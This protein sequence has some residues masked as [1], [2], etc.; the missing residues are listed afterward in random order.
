MKP[1]LLAATASLIALLPAVATAEDA[2]QPREVVVKGQRAAPNVP[3]TTEGVTAEALGRAVNVVTPEDALRYVPNVLIR[4][5]HFGDTQSPVTTRTSGVGASG[6]S[7][8]Y[9]DGILISSLIGN[10]NTSASPKWGLIAPDAIARVDVMYGPFSAA[11][12]GNSIGSVIAFTTRMPQ[13]FEVS[14]EVQGAVQK[15]QRYGDDDS[16]GTA[17]AATSI[18]NRTGA[19]AWRLNYNHLDTRSQPLS[20]VTAATAPAGTTGAFDDSNRLGQPIKVL[21][22]DGLEHQVQDNLSGRLTWDV[23]PTLTAA[24]TFGV[25]RNDDDATV[26]SYLKDA[27]GAPAYTPAFSSGVYHF[28][29]QQIA[30]GLSLTSHSGGV[31]DYHLS[32][33]N[34][35]YD[36]SR[37]RTPTAPPQVAFTGGAGVLAQ[38]DGT[39]WRTFDA[40]GTW[41][42]AQAH[43]VTFGYHL[44]AFRLDNPRYALADWRTNAP[45]AVT[46]LSAGR[47]VTQGLWL[48]DAM[49]LGPRTKLT[50][51]LRFEHWRA[52]DGHNYSAT[53]ALDVHQPELQRDAVSPKLVFSFNPTPEW[54]LKA[55]DGAAA[56]FPTVT[57]LYQA[58]TTGPTLSVPNPALRPERAVSTEL[59]VERQWPDASLRVSLFDERIRDALLSQSAPLVPGSSTLYTYVQNVDRTVA[60]GMELV[61]DR[62]DVLIDGLD[63]SGWLTWT[64]ARTD[65]DTA[66]PAAQAKHLPQVPR[67]RGAVVATWTPN[68]RLD[69]SIAA[70]YSDRVYATIDNS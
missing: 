13:K 17:R 18:G 2:D 37:Q 70:R 58:I 30:Q 60:H 20:Y 35:T 61:A 36:K 46:V 51:G 19:L 10:N 52:F 25:F 9:V 39:G 12:A 7:L 57:E 47:T 4:Q 65:K 67:L 38:L 8:I 14:A 45:R 68:D 3:T 27:S 44:D 1:S 63:I 53:P 28:E 21:G 24:Y 34:F 59:S 31:F 42:P 55:S 40:D 23:T 11:Y 33:S 5:R 41:R 15:F 43:L 64:E 48:Q 56:R 26:H 69:V 6:R 32:A 29:E 66:F 22:A 50:A 54:T 16:Y 62:Q 49:R